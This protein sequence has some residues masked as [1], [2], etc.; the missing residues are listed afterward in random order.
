[1]EAVHSALGISMLRKP[2]DGGR[3][4]LREHL[5]AESRW[6]DDPRDLVFTTTVGTPMD[7]VAVTRRSKAVVAAA[8]LP[9]QR[10]HDLRHACASLLLAKGVGPRVVME[11]LGPARWSGADTR[12]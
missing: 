4:Q 3:R 10:F 7:G 9:T 11:T 2:R 5:L 6:R 12:I 1:M 8:D